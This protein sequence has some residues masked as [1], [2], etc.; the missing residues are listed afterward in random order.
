MIFKL[1]WKLVFGGIL[2]IWYLSNSYLYCNLRLKAGGERDD[3]GW[4][5]WMAPLTRWTWVSASSGSWWWTGKPGVLQSMGSQRVGYD[6][7]EPKGRK[8]CMYAYTVGGPGDAVKLQ[9]HR[10][11]ISLQQCSKLFSKARNSLPSLNLT[12]NRT[13][14]LTK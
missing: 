4:D 3:R 12:T 11:A 9:L 7:T 2:L 6:W 1:G 8:V 13:P 14:D 10:Q 5:G